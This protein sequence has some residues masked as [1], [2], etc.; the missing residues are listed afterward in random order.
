MCC[1]K[2]KIPITARNEMLD[3]DWRASFVI[4]LA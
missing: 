2:I 3:P 1:K 4:M